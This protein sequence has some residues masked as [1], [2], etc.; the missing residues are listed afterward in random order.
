MKRKVES[1]KISGIEFAQPYPGRVYNLGLGLTFERDKESGLWRETLDAAAPTFC[2]IESALVY[3]FASGERV[4]KLARDNYKRLRAD[5]YA[6]SADDALRAARMYAA[7]G[8]EWRTTRGAKTSNGAPYEGRGERW[9]WIENPARA[10]FRF[11]GF[12]DEIAR[13]NHT[14]WFTDNFQDETLRG[15]VYQLPARDGCARFYPGIPDLINGDGGAYG[16]TRICVSDEFRADKTENSDHGARDSGT[17]RDCANR[18]DHYA[19]K[20]AEREREYQSAWRAG[21]DYAQ[22]RESIESERKRALA[23]LR[24]MHSLRRREN[25]AP[26]ICAELRARISKARDEIASARENMESLASGEYVDDGAP[27]FDTRDAELRDAFNDAAGRVVL[28]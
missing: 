18:A 11:V 13:L 23:L 15:A 6:Q 19:E 3:Y 5:I 17:A 22:W 20:S 2:T 10:G 7:R 4:A 8:I 26:T 16:P 28:V 1:V 12:A 21:A 25:D 27:G 9:R 14:G 24:E